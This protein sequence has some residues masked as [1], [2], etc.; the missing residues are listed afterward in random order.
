VRGSL[1][2]ER[3]SVRP[4]PV[5]RHNDVLQAVSGRELVRRGD[6]LRRYRP[7][8]VLVRARRNPRGLDVPHYLQNQHRQVRVELRARRASAARATKIRSLLAGLDGSP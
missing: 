3:G 5:G 1:Y 4:V 6:P 7:P 2:V 8:R